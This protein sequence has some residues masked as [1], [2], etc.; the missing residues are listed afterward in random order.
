MKLHTFDQ[1]N[2]SVEDAPVADVE[3]AVHPIVV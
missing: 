3:P 1:V 2:E